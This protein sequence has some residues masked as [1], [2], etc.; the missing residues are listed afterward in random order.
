MELV[1]GYGV[2]IVMVESCIGGM[3]S[4]VLIDFVGLLVVFEFGFV[5]YSNVVKV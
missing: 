3:I 4:V 5:I 1:C 2:I